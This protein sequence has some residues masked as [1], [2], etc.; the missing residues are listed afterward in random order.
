[1]RF[2][3]ISHLQDPKVKSRFEVLFKKCHPRINLTRILPTK[4]YL[5]N[6]LKP[7]SSHENQSLGP[8]QQTS[9]NLS[10]VAALR[11]LKFKILS[12]PFALKYKIATAEKMAK[13]N[14]GSE[15]CKM[16]IFPWF[17][18]V[19]NFSTATSL[20]NIFQKPRSKSAS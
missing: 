8:T 5:L 19:S 17:Y 18:T 1:M 15:I 2:C 14:H 4:T 12:S 6:T 16:N 3:S 9:K 20:A 13:W 11:N 7:F 10:S